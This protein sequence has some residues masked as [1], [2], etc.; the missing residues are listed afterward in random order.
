MIQ[1]PNEHFERAHE[2][3]GKARDYKL[4]PGENPAL[5]LATIALTEAVLSVAAQLNRADRNAT[6]SSLDVLDRVMRGPT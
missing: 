2:L 4:T 3:L 1:D 5:V 6:M